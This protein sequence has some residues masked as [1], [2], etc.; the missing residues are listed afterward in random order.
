MADV[1]QDAIAWHPAILRDDPWT[2]LRRFAETDGPFS[3][4]TD[5]GGYWLDLKDLLIYG[6]QYVNFAPGAVAN[7]NFVDLPTAGLNVRYPDSDDL[8]GLF[9]NVG[10]N[11]VSQDGVVQLSILGAQTDTTPNIRRLT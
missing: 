2:S 3:V 4:V 5:A 1:M 10:A 7:G 11:T 6:D 8:N 9:A